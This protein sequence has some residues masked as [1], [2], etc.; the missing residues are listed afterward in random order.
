M[1]QY[2]QNY[3]CTAGQIN[4]AQSQQQLFLQKD[5]KS[6]TV[7][8]LDVLCCFWLGLAFQL[9]AQVLPKEK[10]QT[11]IP[12]WHV[13]QRST[14]FMLVECKLKKLWFSGKGRHTLHYEKRALGGAHARKITPSPVWT[15]STI[16]EEGGGLFL[17]INVPI[18]NHHLLNG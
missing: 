7:I 8:N 14:M 1:N 17:K 9:L 5:I 6:I 18:L 12:K 11:I 4:N 15:I 3:S 10:K 2:W 16:E 13:S